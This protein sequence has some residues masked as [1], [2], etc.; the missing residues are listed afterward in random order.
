M[1]RG[2]ITPEVIQRLLEEQFP[3]W[4][5]LPLKPVEPNGWDNITMRLGDTMSVR[6]P[7]AEKYSSQVEKEHAWLPVI[8]NHVPVDIPHPLGKGQP[9]A[10][11]PRPWSVYEWLP[12]EQVSA[13]RIPD[14]ERL[15]EDVSDFLMALYQVDTTG[16]PAAGRHSFY[17][18]ADPS[19]WDESARMAIAALSDVIDEPLATEVWETTLESRWT[20]APAWYHGDMSAGNLLVRDG[21]LSAVI[22][23][24]TCGV[25]DP[26]CDLVIAWSLFHGA[27]R[28][29]F[30]RGVNLDDDTW[31]RARG[32]ML[33]KAAITLR[34]ARDET[35]DEVDT[36][37][38]QF[39]WRVGAQQVLEDVLAE[40]T[41][42]SAR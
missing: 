41:Q 38:K 39:G 35:P 28:E 4:A 7:S 25:G 14:L 5:H 42:T 13:D 36:A 30:R 11:F 19:N 33:W 37:G 20:G 29:S 15:A 34:D 12:G 3:E 1:D 6:L 17:R 18:G 10:H 2:D 16:A 40:H 9:G 26:A 31:A 22:D 21:E 23:F 27:S 8:R 24:G 32:W